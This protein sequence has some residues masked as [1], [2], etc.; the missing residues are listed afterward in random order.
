MKCIQKEPA[1]RHLILT[2]LPKTWGLDQLE[3]EVRYVQPADVF[4]AVAL[5]CGVIPL[6][7]KALNRRNS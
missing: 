4:R 7:M 1:S 5:D 2:K 6:I 3:I